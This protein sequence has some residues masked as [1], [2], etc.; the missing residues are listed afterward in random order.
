MIYRND[1]LFERFNVLF[2]K[3]SSIVAGEE[4]PMGYF[5]AEALEVDDVLLAELEKL[6]QQAGEEFDVFLTAR[7]GSSVGMAIQKLDRAWELIRQ[8]PLYNKLPYRDGCG[9]VVSGM[10]CDLRDDEQNMTVC[11]RLERER[12]NCCC[13]G[14]GGIAAWRLEIFHIGVTTAGGGFCWWEP[15]TRCTADG[16][17]REKQNAPA[18]R[19]AL[20]GRSGKGTAGSLPAA[21]TR[22]RTTG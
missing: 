12:M 6:T 3:K 10:I 14:K 15:T 5:A 2:G 19:S 11:S 7:T 18:V 22:G 21:N 4:Y 1:S 20:T 16:R 13:A 8:L 9:S 17:H